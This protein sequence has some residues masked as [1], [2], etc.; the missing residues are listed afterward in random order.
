MQRRGMQVI[1]DGVFNHALSDGIYFDRYDRYGGTP[2]N[3]GAC[4]SL[5][6]QWRSWFNF[7]DN[8]RALLKMPTISGM[9]SDWIACQRSTI[10]S[11]E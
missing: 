11:D 6:S 2:P 5:G 8:N 7:T 3:I 1:L 10:T 9:V 4:L